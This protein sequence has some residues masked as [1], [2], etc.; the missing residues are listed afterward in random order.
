MD[1]NLTEPLDTVN[2]TLLI[3]NVGRSRSSGRSDIDEGSSKN[4]VHRVNKDGRPLREG[5]PAFKVTHV[6]E[7][8]D[9]SSAAKVKRLSISRLNDDEKA[10]ATNDKDSQ[11]GEPVSTRSSSVKDVRSINIV[12]I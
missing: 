10:E 9:P 7:K 6:E 4:H 8:K 2:P 12:K 5:N 1:Y 11:E 3:V